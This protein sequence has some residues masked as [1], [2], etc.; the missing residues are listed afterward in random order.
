MKLLTSL[1]QAAPPL[2]LSCI[3]PQAIAGE[4]F[5][6]FGLNCPTGK[7]TYEDVSKVAESL[8]QRY[9]ALWGKDWIDRPTPPQRIAPKAMEEIAAISA[10]AAIMDQSACATFYDPYF[11]GDVT[12]FTALSTRVPVRRQFDEAIAAI[13]TEHARKAAQSCI[14]RVAKK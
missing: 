9:S 14:K 7:H 11:G 13:P 3:V 4:V 5:S 2:L 10:C 1:L 6:P 8:N 12:V